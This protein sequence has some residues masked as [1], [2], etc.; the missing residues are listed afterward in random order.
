[1]NSKLLHIISIM[2]N[3]KTMTNTTWLILAS[4][5]KGGKQ[6]AEEKFNHIDCNF[7]EL[8]LYCC[9]QCRSISPDIDDYEI[10]GRHILS[11]QICKSCISE[12]TKCDWCGYFT[13]HIIKK[14]DRGNSQLGGI[15]VN[16]VCALWGVC[17][18]RGL[19]N[20]ENIKK[21]KITLSV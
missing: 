8:D 15:T 7:D 19:K 1:M 20:P 11:L 13:R 14:G 17:N 9:Q 5:C 2:V 18:D 21:L 4:T 6:I 16:N 12:F 10:A 3:T